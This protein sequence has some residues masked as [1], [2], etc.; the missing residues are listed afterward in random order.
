MEYNK[1]L[2]CLTLPE[3]S[4]VL[5]IDLQCMLEAISKK[6]E[7]RPTEIPVLV[8]YG[9]LCV[10]E[11]V[12]GEALSTLMDLV[13]GSTDSRANGINT[14]EELIKLHNYVFNVLMEKNISKKKILK[15]FPSMA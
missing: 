5:G 13:K 10:I 14:I 12:I 4:A 3:L 11:K 9:D 8:T 1:N 7:L 6:T 15:M 2:G